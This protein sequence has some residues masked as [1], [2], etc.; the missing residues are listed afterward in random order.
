MNLKAIRGINLPF[1]G[2]MKMQHPFQNGIQ[3]EEGSDARFDHVDQ[4]LHP[5]TG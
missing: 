2:E 4:I 5:R 1:K 3:S